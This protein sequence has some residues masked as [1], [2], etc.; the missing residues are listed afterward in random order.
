A[1]NGTYTVYAQVYDKDGAVGGPYSFTETVNNSPPTI[2]LGTQPT[3]TF[4]EG[5]AVG[6]FAATVTDPANVGAVMNDPITYTW[7]VTKNG[8]AFGTPVTGVVN[9]VANGVAAVPAFG[10]TPD[11]DATYVVTLAVSD[12]DG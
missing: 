3:G 9:T 6:G 11:D 2:T 8:A 1:D 12:G 7:S 4:T 10:F 5:T